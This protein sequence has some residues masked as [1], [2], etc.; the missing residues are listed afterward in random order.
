MKD[1]LEE[2]FDKF[3]DEFHVHPA[4]FSEL[5]AWKGQ[6]E[7]MLTKTEATLAMHWNL[8]DPALAAFRRPVGGNDDDFGTDSGRPRCSRGLDV[9]VPD[10][11]NWSLDMLD[12]GDKTWYQWRKALRLQVK[13]IWGSWTTSSSHCTTSASPSTRSRTSSC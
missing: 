3:K 11:R 7:N 8:I 6:V 10:P 12:D 1:T 5:S 13:S 2:S 9:R 4:K